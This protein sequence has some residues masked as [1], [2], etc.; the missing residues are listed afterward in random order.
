MEQQDSESEIKLTKNP[1]S[2]ANIFSILT[3]YWTIGLFRKGYNQVLQINDLY[4]P[5]KEDESGSLGDRLET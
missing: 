1:R 4:Q 5:L 2:T 3:F